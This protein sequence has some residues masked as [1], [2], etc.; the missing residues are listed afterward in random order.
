MRNGLKKKRNYVGFFK[1][2]WVLISHIVS[3]Q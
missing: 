1:Y 2:L 3:Q